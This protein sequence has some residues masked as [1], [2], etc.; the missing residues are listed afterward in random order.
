M[1]QKQSVRTSVRIG[2]PGA[3][4]DSLNVWEVVL[5]HSEGM[6]HADGLA[7]HGLFHI[8]RGGGGA[9]LE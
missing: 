5:V 4:E 8:E 2:A 1:Y 3:D 6:L 9:R 7:F